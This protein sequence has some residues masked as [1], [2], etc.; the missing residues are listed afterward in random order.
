VRLYGF[1]SQVMPF[2]DRDLETR[3]S[4]CRFLELKLPRDSRS[5]GLALD[6]EVA[7]AHYRLDKTSEGVIELV[8]EPSGLYGPT[9]VGSRVA[10]EHEVRLSE[11]ID[12]LNE[13]FGTSFTPSD[14]L[15]VL[16]AI[17]AEAVADASV[18]LRANANEFDNFARAFRPKVEE[19]MLDRMERNQ[20]IVTRYLNDP[21]FRAVVD[22]ELA[23]RTYDQIRGG[24]SSM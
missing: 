5:G 14:Q 23:R 19:L 10:K 13:K 7:L 6:D 16:D 2:T 1:L 9:E 21:E 3:Y 22:Q 8:R 12:I 17:R 18:V 15:A 20:D 4:F 11:I 24:P